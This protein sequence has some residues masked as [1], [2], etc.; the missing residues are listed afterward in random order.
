MKH[1]LVT[2]R[3]GTS[4][5]VRNV[6][7]NGR[8]IHIDKNGRALHAHFHALREDF[9]SSNGDMAMTMSSCRELSDFPDPDGASIPERTVVFVLVPMADVVGDPVRD[10]LRLWTIVAWNGPHAEPVKGDRLRQKTIWTWIEKFF[11]DETL[12]AWKHPSGGTRTEIWVRP[13]W[14][15][16]KMFPKLFP[17]S[18]K[19]TDAAPASELHDE[20][21]RPPSVPRPET[22]QQTP[23][24]AH[25]PKTGWRFF[26]Y[27]GKE[28]A[29]GF[30][31][32]EEA[33]TA[34][35]EY[36]HSHAINQCLSSAN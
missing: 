14:N 22:P 9:E 4:N 7:L 26:G 21:E 25:A 13:S 28:V 8:P 5:Y 2:K 10:S 34:M 17:P 3:A 30:R 29:R 27:D 18:G 19:A 20:K 15:A 24:I 6:V 33:T 1:T 11:N 16:S 36:M 12:E 35:N 31:S 23:R 32:K